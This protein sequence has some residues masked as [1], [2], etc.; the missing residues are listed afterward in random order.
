[1]AMSQI[2]GTPRLLFVGVNALFSCRHL[3]AVAAASPVSC[4]VETV[5]PLGKLK[6]LERRLLHSRLART[7]SAIGAH[8]HEV[9][10]RDPDAL[11]AIMRD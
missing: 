1:M 8:H 5:R 3:E 4:V 9:L 11:L 10:D 7:A 2:A 6:R